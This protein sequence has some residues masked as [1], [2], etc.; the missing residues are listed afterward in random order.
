[1]PGDTIVITGDTRRS[2]AEWFAILEGA[3]FVAKVSVGKTAKALVPADPDSMSGKAK[4][5]RQFGIPIITEDGLERLLG[6]Q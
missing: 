3:G 5:A 4:Q 6:L 2:R 1:M